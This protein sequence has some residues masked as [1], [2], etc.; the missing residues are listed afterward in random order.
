MERAETTDT[1]Q[2]L[3]PAPFEGTS[4]GATPSDEFPSFAWGKPPETGAQPAPGPYT[5]P[6]TDL[7]SEEP[8]DEPV[9]EPTDEPTDEP[10]EE[11]TDD[12]T[13]LGLDDLIPLL[14]R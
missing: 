14:R 10:T 4:A 2:P 9:E 6:P 7:P 12:G 8:T 13:P 5:P 1:P 3:T 11:P